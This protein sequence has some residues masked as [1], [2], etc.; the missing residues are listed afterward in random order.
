[1]IEAEEM[2][3]RGPSTNKYKELDSV[4]SLSRRV[5]E[6]WQIVS[7]SFQRTTSR[8]SV[9]DS[10][11]VQRVKCQCKSLQGISQGPSLRT[12]FGVS[13]NTVL[14]GIPG[15]NHHTIHTRV[16]YIN[17]SIFRRYDATI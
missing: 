2:A 14:Q 10:A 16:P 6:A 13:I 1:M 9:S 8:F 17:P 11:S 12:H 3:F 5:I 4:L 15:S 7:G